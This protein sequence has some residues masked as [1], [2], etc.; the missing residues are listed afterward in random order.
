MT[1][2]RPWRAIKERRPDGVYV[3]S[4]PLVNANKDRIL[5]VVTEE[6]IPTIFGFREFVDAGGLMSYGANFPD[7]FC[8]RC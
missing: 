1:L 7:L 4:E 5:R 6:R 2:R 3:L 8:S